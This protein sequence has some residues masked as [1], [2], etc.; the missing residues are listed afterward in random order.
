MIDCSVGIVT[1]NHVRTIGR[2]LAALRAN[3]PPEL[4]GHLYVL[5]N[6]S[7]DGT[8]DL[9]ER[10]ARENHPL[11]LTLLRSSS[12]NCGYG[13][14]HN[15]I[16]PYLNSRI[17]LLMNPDIVISRPES[18]RALVRRLD[19]NPEIGLVMPKIIDSAGQVQHLARRDLT[20]LDLL[21]RYLP[22]HWFKQRE[23]WHTMQDHD[24]DQPFAIE[25]ASGCLM[26]L[27]TADLKAIGGFDPRYF[28]YAEDADLSRTV[29]ARGWQVFYEP[30]A[31]VE[32]AWTRGSY[33]NPR[34]FFVHCRS[35]WRYFG[36]WG[37]RF[38]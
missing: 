36:K 20:I 16:L 10:A 23:R 32:H 24:Y 2:T 6:G 8:L 19:Q 28:L 18:I 12:G 17:H 11:P 31:E 14:G 3:W 7:T 34:L 15:Q 30:A 22:G 13:A 35:L 5:D 27:R 33:R 37:F 21:V 38:R 29:R 26:A 4:S 25:F 1:Y 9:L